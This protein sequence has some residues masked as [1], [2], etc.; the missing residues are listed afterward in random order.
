MLTDARREK[1]L[2]MKRSS[3]AV[4]SLVLACAGNATR[5]PGPTMPPT[6]RASAD[7]PAPKPSSAI[8]DTPA[9]RVLQELL[10]V[11][12]AG[13]KAQVEAFCAKYKCPLPADRLLALRQQT[14]GFTLLG[15]GKSERLR[16]RYLVGEKASP[17]IAAGV[18]D[19]ADADPPAIARLIFRIVPS[20]TTVDNMDVKVDAATR[21]RVI[22]GIIGKLTEHYVFP[23][24]AKKMEEAL[25][26][27][28]KNGEYDAVVEGETF[29]SLLTDH[30]QAIS[31]DKHLR[32]ECAP[33]VLPKDDAK[34]PPQPDPEM[35]AHLERMNCGFEKAERI[36]TMIGYVKLNMFAPPDI[37]A[38]RATAAMGALGDV[39]A[40]IF[41]LRDNGGGDPAMVAFL[42][43]Y[44]FSKRT[45]LNDLWT[46]KT[47]KTQEFW[48]DPKV[49]GKKFPDVP[50]FVL[51]AKQ[52]FSGAEEFAY[53]LKNLK[54]A[55][56]VGETTGGGAH[57]TEGHRLD[58]HFLI[59]VPFARAVSPITKTNWEGTGVEPDVKVAA[60]QALETAK[61]IAREKIRS[62]VP[63][64]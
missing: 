39:D 54:R 33:N 4:A 2:A 44:L 51:T 28:Q 17:T 5:Q 52:T 32:V 25:R 38:P 47:N 3:A 10:D 12:N 6:T 37:C 41:D 9:G 34:D 61:K 56:I 21:T 15:V 11:F 59:G 26:A 64:P 16:I 62:R 24:T 48:T 60:D 20:G 46:R 45:H 14:G 36:D 50:V 35:R 13:E 29:A 22:D 58:D 57:P 42:S 43:S 7:P 55:T 49:P 63:R 53:N 23:E 8:P 1:L 27:H 30:L 19:L 18:L 40:I 31:H